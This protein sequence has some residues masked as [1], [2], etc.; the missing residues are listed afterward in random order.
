[1]TQ[2][3]VGTTDPWDLP[4]FGTNAPP[5]G[6]AAANALGEAVNDALDSLD[7]FRGCRVHRD[8]NFTFSDDTAAEV[9]FPQET[10]DPLNMHSTSVNTSRLTVPAGYDGVWRVV[11]QLR[12]VFHDAGRRLAAILLNGT[13]VGVNVEMPNDQ[14][15][16]AMQVSAIVAAT[17]GDYFE[18]QGFQNRGGSLIS[19]AGSGNTWFSAEF[20][21]TL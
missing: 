12:F 18:L 17:E 6:P 16:H 10:F 11:G 13:A 9:T 15:S 8:G 20:L 14:A 3:I 5:S 4:I 2:Q 19:Q 1:M 21:G 7:A